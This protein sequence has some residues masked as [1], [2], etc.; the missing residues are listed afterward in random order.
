MD[1]VQNCDSYYYYTKYGSTSCTYKI[2]NL[3]NRIKK[4]DFLLC[5]E[6]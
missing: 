1:N 2:L 6:V 5:A 3:R 4:S